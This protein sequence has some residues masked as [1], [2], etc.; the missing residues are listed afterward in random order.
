MFK[1]HIEHTGEIISA[2]DGQV[3]LRFVRSNSCGSCKIHS[4]CSM[5]SLGSGLIGQ[6]SPDEKAHVEVRLPV[7][8][9]SCYKAKAQATVELPV[10]GLGY[11][12]ALCYLIFPVCMLLGAW[13]MTLIVPGS[14]LVAAG[15]ALCGL[16]VGSFLL[17]LYDAQGGGQR[18]LA[19]LIVRPTGA[20]LPGHT[21]SN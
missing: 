7:A 19:K 4:V 10:E 13:L 11:L 12:L 6:G 16:A 9:Y 20:N 18:L 3:L 15:G 5:G 21:L 2:S 1:T 8:E 14:D 17:W